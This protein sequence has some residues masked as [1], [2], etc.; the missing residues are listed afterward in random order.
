MSNRRR[1][2]RPRPPAEPMSLHDVLFTRV[3]LTDDEDCPW[4]SLVG[5]VADEDPVLGQYLAESGH[6]E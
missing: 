2:P 1:L 4:C 3:V 5:Q 6:V